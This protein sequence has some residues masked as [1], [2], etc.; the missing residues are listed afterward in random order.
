MWNHPERHDQRK[1]SI[2]RMV[3]FPSVSLLFI[4]ERT[5][6]YL[7]T[8]SYTIRSYALIRD[9]ISLSGH[10]GGLDCT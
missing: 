4:L 2:K 8:E 1:P 9:F 7:E 3:V 6:I 10:I 5:M